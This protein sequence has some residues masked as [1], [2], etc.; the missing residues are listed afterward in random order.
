MTNIFNAF[1]GNTFSKQMISNV[2]RRVRVA[3]ETHGRETKL[4]ATSLLLKIL[5]EDSSS[6]TR[7]IIENFVDKALLS[8]DFACLKSRILTCRVLCYLDLTSSEQ[9]L[10]F[11]NHTILSHLD[12]AECVEHV[13]NLLQRLSSKIVHHGRHGLI[14]ILLKAICIHFNNTRALRAILFL[15]ESLTDS[16]TRDRIWNSNALSKLCEAVRNH[17][18]SKLGT[19]DV[20]SIMRLVF[21]VAREE[22]LRDLGLHLDALRWMKRYESYDANLHETCMILVSKVVRQCSD[23]DD[24]GPGEGVSIILRSLR[25]F[26]DMHVLKKAACTLFC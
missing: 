9:S 1:S 12:D 17:R 18:S 26:S 22:D 8:T 5:Y 4:V 3:L 25:T 23:L 21:V 2:L 6:S 15:L 16:E 24:L 10:P 20:S 13:S 11:A 7:K 19:S 14:D